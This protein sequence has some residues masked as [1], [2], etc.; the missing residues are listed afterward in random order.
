MKKNRGFT[1]VE[2]LVV[3]AIVA[4]L[5]A[6]IFP[7]FANARERARQV[8]CLS[9]LKQLTSGIRMYCDDNGGRVPLM[10][11]YH[12]ADKV[13]WCGSIGT[14]DRAYV[15]RGSLFKYVKAKG[16]YLCPS[17]KNR[18]ANGLTAVTPRPRDYPL[19]YPMNGELHKRI[20]TA[21]VWEPLILDTIPRPAKVMMLIHESRDTIND[22]LYLWRN[23]NLDYPDK[24]HYDGT[25]VSYCDGHCKWIKNEEIVRIQTPPYPA[26][27]SEWDPDPKR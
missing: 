16:A 13:N 27:G 25:T 2:L 11:K 12:F 7:I 14:Y 15:E 23:N 3:I 21:W 5:A 19:S 22:G 9:N 24:I 6:I 8:S 10:S 1:L 4:I 17:D 18:P 20:G 26:E